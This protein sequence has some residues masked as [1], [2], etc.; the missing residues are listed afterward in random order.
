MVTT[1]CAQTQTDIAL[2][3][4]TSKFLPRKILSPSITFHLSFSSISLPWWPGVFLCSFS[5]SIAMATS[6]SH[7]KLVFPSSVPRSFSWR[8]SFR[9]LS[10]PI[11]SV[12]SP[13]LF[14]LCCFE[15]GG[16]SI[17]ISWIKRIC[18]K[19]FIESAASS[20]VKDK[21]GGEVLWSYLRRPWA[22]AARLANKHMHR[23]KA[24]YQCPLLYPPPGIFVKATT[25][26]LSICVIKA[27]NCWKSQ[28]YSA[29]LGH[30]S[31]PPCSGSLHSIKKTASWPKPS[32]FL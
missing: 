2:V 32:Q 13:I 10:L 25:M 5:V 19:P 20:Q 9:Y 30:S 29:P 31:D 1:W 8:A 24:N 28:T 23:D 15:M 16:V 3:F 11:L 6:L 21:D 27:G 12:F 4:L 7:G 22:T 14:L 26:F 17:S 18:T